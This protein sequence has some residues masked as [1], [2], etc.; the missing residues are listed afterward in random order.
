LQSSHF[1]TT[2]Y[3]DFIKTDRPVIIALGAGTCAP[4][5]MLQPFLKELILEYKDIVDIIYIDVNKER[6]K[7]MN[8]PLQVIPTQFFFDKNRNETFR[9]EGYFS[10]EEIKEQLKKRPLQENLTN[11]EGKNR[12]KLK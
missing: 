8:F 6:N 2:D 10:K 1:P 9:H 4:C 12:N 5:Q 3:T 7:A 11:N